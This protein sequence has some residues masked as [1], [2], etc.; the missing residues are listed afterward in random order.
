MITEWYKSASF[1]IGDQRL[2]IFLYLFLSRDKLCLIHTAH[3]TQHAFVF[4]EQFPGVGAP[5]YLKRKKRINAALH[6]TGQQQP[7][8]PVAIGIP[9]IDPVFFQP[10]ADPF[11]SGYYNR[12]KKVDRYNRAVFESDVFPPGGVIKIDFR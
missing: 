9:D 11:V 4:I 5:V 10:C 7:Y 8:I 3:D 2:Q 12:I 6:K 1:D